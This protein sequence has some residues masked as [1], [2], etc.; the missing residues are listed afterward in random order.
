MQP[1]EEIR[2]KYSFFDMEPIAQ[3]DELAL[4]MLL[5]VGVVH[6]GVAYWL[7]FGA[8]GNVPAQTAALLSYLDPVIAILLSALVLGEA[9]TLLT[10]LGALLVLGATMA[11]EMPGKAK[12]GQE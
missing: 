9:M 12:N 8:M 7:Y 1:N 6:T 10:G 4:I 3:V 2:K 11:S 5:I